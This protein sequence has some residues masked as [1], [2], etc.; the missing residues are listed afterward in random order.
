MRKREG[1]SDQIMFVLPDREVH[2]LKYNDITS[3]LYFTDIG[4]YP[5]ARYHYR[6]RNLGAMQNILMLCVD[7]K[8]WVEI[9]NERHTLTKNQYLII[10]SGTPHKYGANLN[11]PWTIY[12]IH[13]AGALSGQYVS[14]FNAIIS[15]PESPNER[16]E[17]RISLF[18]EIFRNLERGYSTQNLEYSCIC[19]RQILGSFKYLSQFRR[20]N[21]HINPDVAT[22]AIKF[23]KDNID[24]KVYLKEIAAHCGLSVS[25]FSLLFKQKMHHAPLDYLNHLRIQ[26]ACRLLD[27]SSLK[28]KEVAS[29]VGFTDVLYFSKVFR[30]VMGHPPSV[31]RKI[32]R[33]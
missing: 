26:L 13:F 4:Y 19:L 6:E 33:G 17:A 23:M 25:H 21:E 11:V 16:L 1:F 3:G 8:G 15:L 30:K 10:A 24:R 20:I 7:G 29:R 28:V 12:W 31:Y 9:E 18:K 2:W 22:T 14:D 5:T 32:K 27:F